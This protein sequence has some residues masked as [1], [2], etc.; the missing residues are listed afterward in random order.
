[1]YA[2]IDQAPEARNTRNVETAKNIP[3]STH[4]FSIPGSGFL[5]PI[6]LGCLSVCGIVFIRVEAKLNR[7]VQDFD[8]AVA[9]HPKW[10]PGRAGLA[11]AWL[12]MRADV[13]R[14]SPCRELRRREERTTQ[15]EMQ[16][17]R[18]DPHSNWGPLPVELHIY[19]H[20]FFC[21]IRYSFLA[22]REFQEI[23]RDEEYA[24]GSRR[25]G[26]RQPI[27]N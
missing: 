14:R 8:H 23:C 4:T 27:E 26:A 15:A 22:L 17:F 9:K 7:S 20:S 6:E 21:S 16:D 11:L 5:C 24:G 2:G 3:V 1:M 13:R 12:S 18:L 10:V 25:E 19:A